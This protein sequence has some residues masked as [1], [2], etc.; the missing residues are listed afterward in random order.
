MLLQETHFRSK[1]RNRLK[2]W[3]RT[4]YANNNL[5]RAGLAILIS[6]KIVC[7]SN[8]IT[9]DDEGHCMLTVGSIQDIT[10]IN[11]YAQNT[12]LSNI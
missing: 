3:N 4:F 11:I 12:E 10:Y 5:Q 2:E 6:N 7:K 1:D 8:I 9:R